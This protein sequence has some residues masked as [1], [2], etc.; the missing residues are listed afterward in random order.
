MVAGFYV[1]LQPKHTVRVF[2]SVREAARWLGAPDGVALRTLVA[3]LSQP[4]AQED[5][6]VPRLRAW[7]SQHPRVGSPSA[8]AKA[9]SLSARTLQRKLRAACTTFSAQARAV[10]LER[11]QQLLRETDWKL[12]AVAHEVGFDS[13][14]RLATTFRQ[15]TGLTP[16]AF[17]AQFRAEIAGARPPASRD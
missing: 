9:L 14:Q 6:V 3:V 8:A 7:L 13:S 2:E 5:G 17:R 12:A 1:Q 15:A 11:A 4:P 10:K 16:S